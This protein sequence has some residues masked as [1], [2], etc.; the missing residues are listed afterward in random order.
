MSD[1]LRMIDRTVICGNCGK[2]PPQR[3]YMTFPEM[4]QLVAL[5]AKLWL[6]HD[7][8]GTEVNILLNTP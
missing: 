6:G 2:G 8:P 4:P 5:W 3:L 1:W 7:G